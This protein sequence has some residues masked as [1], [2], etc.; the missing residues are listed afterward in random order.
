[1]DNSYYKG[2]TEDPIGRLERHNKGESTYTRNKIPWSHV[3]LELLHSKREALIRE[4][5]VKKY[6]HEQIKQLIASPKN[7]LATFLND[8]V[9]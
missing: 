3:Y 5:A 9:G 4:K 6:S 7:Y 8:A 2:F 1:M